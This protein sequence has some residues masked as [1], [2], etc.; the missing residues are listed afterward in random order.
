[1]SLAHDDPPFRMTLNEFVAF[2]A[3]SDWRHELVDGVVY[4]MAGE[5]TEH[6]E[7]AGA[8]YVRLRDAARR[9]GCRITFESVLVSTKGRY[10]FYPDVMMSC[11]TAE[12]PRVETSPCLIVEV[13]SP[14]T[15]RFDQTA[16]HSAYTQIDSMRAYLLVNGDRSNPGGELHTWAGYFWKRQILQPDDVIE[17]ACPEI[18][19]TLAEIYADS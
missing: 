4:A 11:E 6:N 17:L 13:L 12:H 18:T 16:K 2:E 7:I 14:S 5:T 8:L 19:F 15:A 1:M 3:Q 10:G 9:H